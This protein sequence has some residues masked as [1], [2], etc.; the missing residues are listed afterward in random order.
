MGHAKL[1]VP[2]TDNHEAV[3]ETGL[4][5]PMA[6]SYGMLFART[7]SEQDGFVTVTLESGEVKVIGHDTTNNTLTIGRLVKGR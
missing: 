1:V 5:D 7:L 6:M 3:C 2:A 4:S